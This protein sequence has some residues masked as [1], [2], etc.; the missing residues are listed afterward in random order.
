[1]LPVEISFENKN[2]ETIIVGDQILFNPRDVGECLG[3]SEST[4]RDHIQKMSEKQVVKITNKRMFKDL[5][6]EKYMVTLNISDVLKM[7]MSIQELTAKINK[8]TFRKINNSGENFVTE[9]GLYKL[10]FKTDTDF[11]IK[12]QELICEDTTP[13]IRGAL[14][15]NLLNG[16]KTSSI[17][18]IYKA[19]RDTGI[20]FGLSHK[21][22]VIRALIALKAETGFDIKDL[23]GITPKKTA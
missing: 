16:N 18:G 14:L 4:V 22:A 5:S 20:Y 7:K 11:A 6:D 10:I 17:A 2:I 21:D 1:M 23:L 9:S 13:I 19:L 12:L 15:I 3:I 8:L